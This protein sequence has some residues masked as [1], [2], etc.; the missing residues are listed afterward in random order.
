MEKDPATKDGPPAPPDGGFRAYLVAFSSFLCNGIIF[1]FVNTYSIIYV[2]IYDQMVLDGL[3]NAASRASL[4]GS[5]LM[6]TTFL[7]SPF[8]GVL[9]DK[10]GV[11]ITVFMGCMLAALGVFLSSFVAMSWLFLTYGIMYGAGISLIY[12]PTLAILSH[13]FKKYI[14]FVNGFVSSGSALFSVIMPF[15]RTALLDVGLVFC[16]R[17]EA[18][19]M[20][21]LS[22]T[23]FAFKPLYRSPR[24][25]NRKKS[26]DSRFQIGDVIN[27]KIWKN[28]KFLIWMTSIPIAMMGYFVLYVHL[29]KYIKDNFPTNDFKL[30]LVSM[31]ISAGIGKLA[32][33][34]VSDY[35]IIDGITI[36]QICMVVLGLMTMLIPLLSTYTIIL[37]VCFIMGLFD[38][39]FVSMM[40]PIATHLCGPDGASQ[41]LGFLFGF[42]SI[43]IMIGPP[44]AGM[45]YDY[46]KSYTIPFILAGIPPLTAAMMLCTT[47][48]I[49][50]GVSQSGEQKIDM[51]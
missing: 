32:F 12:T 40:G 3:S 28:T 49:G 16:L 2:K 5:L 38:G 45:I 26:D 30:P 51:L 48:F 46:T 34:H 23:A 13:Y 24:E 36:Q 47:R 15:G 50:N 9:M 33:G 18:M 25:D 14:G 31:A 19:V 22:I 4:V 1:G 37:V 39:G 11:R 43:P 21:G 20:V 41:A 10:I 27:T 42:C 44:I 35:D 17:I 7:L 8:A 6:G 29:V